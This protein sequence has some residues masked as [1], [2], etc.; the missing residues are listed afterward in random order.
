LVVTVVGFWASYFTQMRDVPFA[1]HVHAFSATSWLLLLIVQSVSIHRRQNDFHKLMGKASLVLFP[2]LIAGFV[3]IINFSAQRFAVRDSLFITELGPAFGIGMAI[4]IAAYLTLYYLALQYRRNI[5]LHAGFMLATPLILFESS[6][7][8]VIS[9]YLPWMN[10]IGS[11]GPRQALDMI[12]ISDVLVAIFALA[13]YAMDRKNGLP[14]LVAVFFVLLQAVIMWF[15]PDLPVMEALFLTYS[16][17]PS[18]VS[19]FAGLVA[20][21]LVSYLGWI[22]GQRPGASNAANPKLV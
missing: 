17:I 5:R 18:E 13:L 1:F 8:R 2:V 6:F 12:A 3:M 21:G 9:Q 19:V 16:R 15:T 22:K 14:W 4:A 7:S 10:I 20:G 11:E